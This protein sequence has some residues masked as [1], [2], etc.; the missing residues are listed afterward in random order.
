MERWLLISSMLILGCSDN[1]SDFGFSLAL[2]SPAIAD[3]ARP[4]L[5][6]GDVAIVEVTPLPLY[7]MDAPEQAV[8]V[9]LTVASGRLIC[10]ASSCLSF[11][12]DGSQTTQIDPGSPR[13]WL[14]MPV[15]RAR[16]AFPIYQAPPTP[17]DD[18]ITGAA[19]VASCLDVVSGG[20]RQ[21]DQAYLEIV[22]TPVSDLSVLASVDG[23]DAG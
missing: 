22:V 16:E 15:G 9:Q 21:T 17:G 8:C 2:F 19:F 20:Q 1:P 11:A 23:G 6:A 4:R 13:I 14:Q 5:P 18:A 12:V 3:S 7:D 10:P